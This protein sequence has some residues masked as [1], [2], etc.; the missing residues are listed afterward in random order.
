[1]HLFDEL[2]EDRDFSEPLDYEAD[3]QNFYVTHVDSAKQAGTIQVLGGFQ[4][5]E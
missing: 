2:P 1:M 5:R 3:K 4:F